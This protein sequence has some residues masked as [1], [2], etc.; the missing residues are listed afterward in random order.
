MD[1]AT[2]NF[3]PGCEEG[4]AKI[5]FLNTGSGWATSTAYAVSTNIIT[6]LVP[7]GVWLGIQCNSP[8]YANW[9]GNGQNAQDVLSTV[10]YPQGGTA[11]ISYAKSAQLNNPE[12]PISLLT[13]AS[14]T[15]NNGLWHNCRKDYT[16]TGG[17]MY[18][19]LG[20]RDRKFAGF[21]NSK[22][23]MRTRSPRHILIKAM[24]SI[25]QMA[26]KTTAMVRPT[27]H[28]G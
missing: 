3:C 2:T 9:T 27:T 23:L 25:V 11:S 26:S 28:L 4:D 1:H 5:V 24:D 19:G 17:K 10:T 20:V 21:F 15:S 16:F 18:T 7:G 13:V 22:E 12:L 14:I 6:G 8:D